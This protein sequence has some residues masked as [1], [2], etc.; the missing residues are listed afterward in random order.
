MVQGLNTVTTITVYILPNLW[1]VYNW[2]LEYAWLLEVDKTNHMDDG[3]SFHVYAQFLG[4]KLFVWSL[5]HTTNDYS[6]I[7]EQ[8][9]GNDTVDQMLHLFHKVHSTFWSF[10]QS[11]IV[12]GFVLFDC[13]NKYAFCLL[14]FAFFRYVFSFAVVHYS[15]NIII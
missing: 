2:L 7:K 12:D 15:K 5:L 6:F 13:F 10:L 4:L 14:I 8:V 9:F 1:F 3:H 11:K